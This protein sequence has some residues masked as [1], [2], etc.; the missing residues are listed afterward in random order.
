MANKKITVKGVPLD[1]E[2][3]GTWNGKH[4]TDEEVI[5]HCK[6]AEREFQ[7]DRRR[8][9][10]AEQA[11]QDAREKEW[12]EYQESLNE[13]RYVN[14]PGKVV[15]ASNNDQKLFDKILAVLFVLAV[16]LLV[17]AIR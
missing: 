3:V 6:K 11:A 8:Q 12:S 16:C 14:T 2:D 13:E 9:R 1:Y 5:E 15:Y 17:V 7:A 10:E 4:W